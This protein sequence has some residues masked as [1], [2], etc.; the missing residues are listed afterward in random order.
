MKT[1][2]I[3]FRVVASGAVA[4]GSLAL[5]LLWTTTAA[6]A[7]SRSNCAKCHSKVHLDFTSTAGKHRD[8]ECTDCHQG[9]PPE[10]VRPYPKCADCHEPHLKTMTDADCGRCHRAHAP[11]TV[12][13]AADIPSDWCL[14][15]HAP[16]KE[17][18]LTGS[19][20]HAAIPCTVC[21]RRNHGATSACADCHGRL[22]PAAIMARFPK[23]GEC[24][25]TAHELNHWPEPKPVPEAPGNQPG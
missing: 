19:P 16:V 15:C 14:A 21:H 20:K 1:N 22:H 4:A 11:K 13:Y 10:V 5:C 17:A 2:Q 12:A 23:C 6:A 24:H 25:H 7:G 18:L 9:H 8:M 3:G